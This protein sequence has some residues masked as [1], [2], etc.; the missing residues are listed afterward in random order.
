MRYTNLWHTKNKRRQHES[1][2]TFF[3]YYNMIRDIVKK[4][5]RITTKTVETYQD[6]VRFKDG[7]HHMY[8]HAKKDPVC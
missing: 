4:T 8:I 5:P 1:N 7:M 3:I 6:I 2:F